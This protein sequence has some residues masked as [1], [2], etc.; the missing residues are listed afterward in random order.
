M[1]EPTNSPD[2][3]ELSLYLR[4]H[5]PDLPAMT[6]LVKF[7]TGQS[8][9]TYLLHTRAGRFVLRTQPTG[10]LLKSAHQVDREF[11]VMKALAQTPVPVPEMIYLG[12]DT[13]NPLGRK[14]FIMAFLPGRIFWDPALP[15]VKTNAE[16]GA[17]YQAMNTALAN[18]HNIDPASIGLSQFGRPGSYFQRQT[19]RWSAQYKASKTGDLPQ[20]EKIIDWLTANQ[21][22]D[23]G[24]VSIVHGDYRIDN[25]IFADESP[26]LIGI[27]DWELSTLGH[28]LAD[29]AYQCMQWRLPN[30]GTMR[31]LSGTNRAKLGIP[32]EKEYLARYCS[33]R[34]IAGID[35]WSFYLV[36]SFFRLAAILQ[37]VYKR[38]L[39]GNAS[40]A[41]RAKKLAQ[42]IPFL[43]NSAIEIIEGGE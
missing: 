3:T 10:Q 42:A 11:T 33:R 43:A 21:P 2:I 26:T 29:L 24:Q 9:P 36:F 28:P 14:F 40:N 37:G 13:D 1:S 19:G 30:A 20:M 27:L 32:R 18:L 7:N 39:D 12:N 15:Q 6:D 17:I 31:G 35:N 23:D 16:R 34:D 5:V 41:A 25:M 8:N 4:T 22:G 38:A